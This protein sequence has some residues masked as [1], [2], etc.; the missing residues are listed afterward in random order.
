MLINYKKCVPDRLHHLIRM[1]HIPAV[2]TARKLESD[3]VY[4]EYQKSVYD[5]TTKLINMGHERICL[6]H[7]FEK[8]P[9]YETHYSQ[10]DPVS[11][12]LQAMSDHNLNTLVSN[13]SPGKEAF[14]QIAQIFQMR[15]R[16]TALITRRHSLMYQVIFYASQHGIRIPDDLY[17][18]LIGHQM[19]DTMG[20]P[21]TMLRHD[22]KT[23]AEKS[24]ETIVAKIDHPDKSLSSCP[25]ALQW[26]SPE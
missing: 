7:V 12:Y 22:S 9:A 10:H 24:V 25:I 5:A 6:A 26:I 1:H 13:I 8:N 15:P 2:W 17:L 18:V 11:G 21:I 23:L 20:V 4:Y 19:N 3:A 14:K 16:P